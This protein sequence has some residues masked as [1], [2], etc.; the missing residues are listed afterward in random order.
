[1][2]KITGVT[3]FA[4]G[5]LFDAC[6]PAQ[7]ISRILIHVMGKFAGVNWLPWIYSLV[8]AAPAL[9]NVNDANITSKTIPTTNA[10]SMRSTA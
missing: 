4:L 3:T 8:H 6:C 1:M 7:T 10:R 9:R 5:K 2:G